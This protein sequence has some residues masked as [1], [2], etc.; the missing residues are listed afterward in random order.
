MKPPALKILVENRKAKHEYDIGDRFEAGISLLG[1]EVKSLRNGRGNLAEA[2]VVI[3]PSGAWLMDCHISPYAQ[4]N[5]FNHEPLRKRQLL[6]KQPELAKMRK[7]TQQKGMALVP[8]KIYVKGSRIKLE[9]AIAK[10]RKNYDKRQALKTRDAKKD[11][12]RASRR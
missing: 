2:Y 11:I 1:S 6:L 12:R 5:Q 9:F 8:L 3:R 7:A 4:A 10:G